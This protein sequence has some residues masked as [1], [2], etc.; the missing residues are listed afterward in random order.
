MDQVSSS[1]KRLLGAVTVREAGI[2]DLGLVRRLLTAAFRAYSSGEH[3]EE[4]SAAILASLDNPG[5][6]D[7]LRNQTVQIAWFED[8]PVAVCGWRMADDSGRA[9][10][11]TAIAVD[12]LYGYLGL[13]R[14]VAGACELGARRAGYRDLVVHASR[15]TEGFFR[16]L[17][18]ETTAYSVRAIDIATSTRV[19]YMRKALPE[20]ARTGFARIAVKP[21]IA[22]KER[23]ANR[24][25]A[26]FSAGS[27]LPS[28]DFGTRPM[29]SKASH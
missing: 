21:E 27:D 24:P 5:M 25:G 16:R 23:P 19:I 3:S 2:D 28:I 18:F 26:G 7:A 9:A 8:K 17:G 12:P 10:R 29:L 14:L 4:E 13:G 6:V 15:A 22:E 20:L 1:K 11:L